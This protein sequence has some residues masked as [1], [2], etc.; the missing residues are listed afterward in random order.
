M[1]ES[2]P[3]AEVEPSDLVVSDYTDITQ[4]YSDVFFLGQSDS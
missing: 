3:E 1:V 2:V 4:A